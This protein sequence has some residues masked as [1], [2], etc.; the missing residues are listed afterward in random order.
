[1]FTLSQ[2]F[3]GDQYLVHVVEITK[4]H[5]LKNLCYIVDEVLLIEFTFSA[6][7]RKI[8]SMF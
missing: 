1:M 4:I 8:L 7:C 5:D 6:N 3:R 2:V